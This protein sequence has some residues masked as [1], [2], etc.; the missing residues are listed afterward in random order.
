MKITKLSIMDKIKEDMKSRKKII[1]NQSD[2]DDDDDDDTYCSDDEE[3]E[4]VVRKKKRGCCHREKHDKHNKHNKHDKHCKRVIEE[5]D[6][7][8]EEEDDDDEEI[9]VSRSSKYKNKNNNNNKN[10]NNKHRKRIIDDED[11]DDDDDDEDDEEEE[12][13][14]RLQKKYKGKQKQREKYNIIF[15]GGAKDESDEWETDDDDVW[16][17]ED[18]DDMTTEN[19]DESVS[20][21]STSEDEDDEDD[22]EEEEEEEVRKTKRKGRNGRNRTSAKEKEKDEKEKE[23]G[24]GT[25]LLEE[26]GSETVEQDILNQLKKLSKETGNK[27]KLFTNCIDNFEK[28]LEKYERKKVK[29]LAKQKDKNTRIYR[30]IMHDENTTNDVTYFKE[31]LSV[32]D[33][34]KIIKE[35]REINK[36]IRIEK[37]YKLM[38]LESNIPVQFK[39]TAIKKLNALK[40]MEPGNGEYYKIKNW[41]DTFMRIP[42]NKYE[43]LPITIEDGVDK[44]HDFMANSKEILDKATYGLTDVKTQIMQMLG[45]LITNPKSIGTSIGIHGPPGTGKTSIVKEGVAKILNRPFAFIALGGAT[46]SSFLE[47]HSYTYEGSTWGKIVQTLIDSRCMNPVFYF[48]ELDKISDTPKGEEI[49]GILTHLTDTTQNSQ[50]HDKYF[51]E[52]DFDLSE[53]LFIFSFND[54]TKVNPILIDRMYMIQTSGY[55]KK[56]KLVISNNYMLPKICEQVKFNKEDIVIPQDVMNHIIETYCDQESGVRNL[57]RCLEIIYTKLNLFRLMKPDTNLF[58]NE[59][60]IK[61]SFPITLTKDNIDKLIKLNKNDNMSFRHMYI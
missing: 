46:D 16:E 58:E 57:K 1:H 33:Q 54:K 7:E 41:I 11:D 13:L 20:S 25:P 37:P 14:R 36:L 47:G 27:C 15:V 43:K 29:K 18:E 42:F 4:E 19:E 56:D 30:K 23:K 2:D 39:A 48:D 24:S 61:V 10:K 45:Q 12:E 50:F 53:C 34:I 17:D 44:C 31:K 52:M 26:K 32:E 21:V 60:N 55:D 35:M 3:E 38:L 22:E 49:A 9:H 40:H 59:I 8:D 51:S 6:D 28:N 5:D